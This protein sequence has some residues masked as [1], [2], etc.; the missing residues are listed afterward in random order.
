MFH[1]PK[2]QL[3][4][5]ERYRK[6][7]NALSFV[8]GVLVGGLVGVGIGLLMAPQAG[9]ETMYLIEEKTKDA[10]EKGKSKIP[11]TG[12]CDTEEDDLEAVVVETEEEFEEE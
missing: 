10:L 11:F 5:L 8:E 12:C 2:R 9:R 3:E 6:K 4:E 1:S 7:T